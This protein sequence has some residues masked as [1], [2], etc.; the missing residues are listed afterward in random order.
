MA[1]QSALVRISS[2]SSGSAKPKARV[3]GTSMWPSRRPLA[4]RSTPSTGQPSPPAARTTASRACVRII[5]RTTTVPSCSISTAT[6]SRRYATPRVGAVSKD[7]ALRAARQR[8]VAGGDFLRPLGFI[9]RTFLLPLS[10]L[11]GIGTGHILMGEGNLHHAVVLKYEARRAGP[12]FVVLLLE[13]AHQSTL[14]LLVVLLLVGLGGLAG[15]GSCAGIVIGERFA[16]AARIGR[17]GLAGAGDEFLL[18]HAEIG[19][20]R[21]AIGNLLDRRRRIRAR[22]GGQSGKA[23]QEHE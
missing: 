22:G 17:I 19:L 23:W 20:G 9:F 16:A 13:P 21:I 6:I 10:P 8:E 5:T 12:V 1:P 7:L 18:G 3:S 2:R 4:L 14:L 11:I 15:Y